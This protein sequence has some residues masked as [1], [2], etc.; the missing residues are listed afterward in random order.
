MPAAEKKCVPC[1]RDAPVMSDAEVQ[2][3]LVQLPE[4]QCFAEEGIKKLRKSFVCNSYADALTFVNA[5]A[6]AAERE[7]HHPLV[8][9]DFKTVT[10][11]WWT[12]AIKGLHQND[13]IMSA[14]CDEIYRRQG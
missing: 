13:F 3:R 7:N 14:E 2:S 5:V 4:W 6:R 1:H 12:H 8:I 9:F 11:V 10:V